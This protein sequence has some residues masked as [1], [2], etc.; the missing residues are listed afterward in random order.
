MTIDKMVYLLLKEDY[1]IEL[2]EGEIEAAREEIYFLAVE[3][4][5]SY[6]YIT[7]YFR[8]L[9]RRYIKK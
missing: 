4:Q 7:N 5:E 6:E 1:I 2:F 8:T 3:T 9:H